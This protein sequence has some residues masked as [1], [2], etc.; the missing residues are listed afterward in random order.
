[1]ALNIDQLAAA[2]SSGLRQCAVLRIWG[3]DVFRPGDALYRVAS[4]TAK[5]SVL[6]IELEDAQGGGREA[7]EVAEPAQGKVKGG[8]LRI[9]A[10][11][12]VE[13]FGRSWK[14]V[15]GVEPALLLEQP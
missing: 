14:P 12:G 4:A 10:A 8:R 9:G 6:R 7:L 11:A 5:G 1:V 15:A 2:I 3:E 13:G